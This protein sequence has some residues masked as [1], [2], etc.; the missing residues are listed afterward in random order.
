MSISGNQSRL[1][2]LFE[3]VLI[4]LLMA[5]LLFIEPFGL[6]GKLVDHLRLNY[7]VFTDEPRLLYLA[8]NYAGAFFAKMAALIFI[9][10]LL[11]AKRRGILDGLGIRPPSASWRSFIFPFMVLSMLIRAYYST[12]PL[13]PNLPIRFVSGEA[14]FI[15]NLFAVPSVLL[16][17][18]IAEELIFRGYLFGAFQRTLGSYAAIIITTVV[19]CGAHLVNYNFDLAH[20]GVMM[21]SDLVVGFARF[22]TGSVFTAMLLHGI[23]NGVSIVMGLV[24][25]LMSGY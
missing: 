7:R 22:K 10:C 16:V 14:T 15:G 6:Y 19:F 18:P 21:A 20:I 4:I 8:F 11:L 9:V 13:V 17:A 2:D 5:C 1:T 3:A 12:D 25:F 23:F 24:F